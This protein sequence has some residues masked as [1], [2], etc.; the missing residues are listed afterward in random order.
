MIY[1]FSVLCIDD[2][3]LCAGKEQDT[4]NI[5]EWYEWWT[6]EKKKVANKES[7]LQVAKDE[8]EYAP[9]KA[10]VCSVEQDS[11]DVGFF[12]DEESFDAIDYENAHQ[13]FD[14]EK[15]PKFNY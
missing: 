8:K 14:P 13:A 4:F 2:C 3:L 6:S 10:R 5:D 1:I 15:S 9:S 11:T 7:L 12:S